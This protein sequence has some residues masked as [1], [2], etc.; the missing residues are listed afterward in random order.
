MK[1]LSGNEELDESAIKKIRYWEYGLVGIVLFIEAFLLQ[2]FGGALDS[3]YSR[4]SDEPAHYVTA[5]MVYEYLKSEDYSDPLGFAEDYYAHYPKVALGHWPPVFYVLLAVWFIFFGVTRISVMCFIAL[6][7]VSTGIVIYHLAKSQFDKRGG[8]FAAI[9]FL[10]L[11]LV[12]QA[13]GVVMLGH[14]VTL[15]T[16]VSVI[17][18]ARFLSTE[19]FI[20]GFLFS[21]FA[22]C[23][24][25]TRGSAWAICLMP[26]L[27]MLF[28]W[29]FSMLTRPVFWLTA[30]P[31]L[32]LCAPWY[33]IMPSINSGATVGGSVFS[34][35]FTQ[36]AVP[37]FAKILFEAIGIVI[38][39]PAILGVWSKLIFPLLRRKQVDL[40][41]SAL[42]AL[43]V[44]TYLMHIFVAVAFD[45]R[46]MLITMPAL[47]LFA[48]AGI[49]WIIEKF[50]TSEY[51]KYISVS[52]YTLVVIIFLL[53][54]FSVS[55]TTNTGYSL[56]LSEI[57][58]QLKT[59]QH[60][61]LIASDAFGEGTII[62]AAA[63]QRSSEDYFLRGSKLFVDQDWSGRV[64]KE[65]FHST[66]EI[67]ELLN[68]IPVNAVILD[69]S[70]NA[71]SQRYYHDML[72]TML[73][74]ENSEW[75]SIG[76]FSIVRRDVEIQ[77]ALLVFVSKDNTEFNLSKKVDSEFILMLYGRK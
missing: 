37:H 73:L 38:F 69:A 62:A 70:I 5:L 55:A 72:K 76:K 47:V 48:V 57:S 59:G 21:I 53:T 11:P 61:V 64:L 26:I 1:N 45:S 20:H 43:I 15:F 2:W 60:A 4:Y 58:K 68:E 56:A 7:A 25:L 17:F 13:T 63:A 22:A 40:M 27:S 74:D 52:I 75:R 65:K 14:M 42:A 34:M 44:A 18:L 36:Q 54:N 50:K 71:E 28:A 31:I 30:I 46:Y 29:R 8:I 23:A 32:V 12:Q 41:W 49:E 10:A 6:I 9:L 16:L 67:A 19:K 3:E 33:L 35:G 66:T 51:D 77:N 24:I 39:I